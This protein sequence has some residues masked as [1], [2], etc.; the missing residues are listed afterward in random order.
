MLLVL[1][2]FVSSFPV[3]F[4]G[5][6][7]DGPVAHWEIY[8]AIAAMGPKSEN[9]LLAK[10]D[11]DDRRFLDQSLRT[12][13][14]LSDIMCFRPIYQLIR[15]PLSLGSTVFRAQSSRGFIAVARV[16]LL[17]RPSLPSSRKK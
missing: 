11:R 16:F 6:Y 13:S 1:S 9:P 7:D 8:L 5:N 4:V 10:R 15:I 17:V 2:D 14:V 3:C 12:V